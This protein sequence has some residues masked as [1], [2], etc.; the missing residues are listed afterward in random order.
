MKQS[1]TLA[2]KETTTTTERASDSLAKSDREREGPIVSASR[3]S[4]VAR[5]HFRSSFAAALAAAAAAAAAAFALPSLCLLA[6]LRSAIVHV[7]SVSQQ[8]CLLCLAAA[9]CCVEREGC[10][11]VRTK[12]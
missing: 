9:S 12:N 4:L 10:T 11:K 3:A 7:R 1:D 5:L 8:L 2:L 6:C